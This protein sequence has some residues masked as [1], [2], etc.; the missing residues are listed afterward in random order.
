M[1]S[2]ETNVFAQRYALVVVCANI[3]LP[4]L[5]KPGNLVMLALSPTVLLVVSYA[6]QYC[7]SGRDTI[8]SGT[9]RHSAHW[10]RE[11]YQL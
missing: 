11:G 3:G 10:S 9:K 7:C 4:E 5:G 2:L 8:S 1:A 6:A